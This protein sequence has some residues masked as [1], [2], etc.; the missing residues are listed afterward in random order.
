MQIPIP[1]NILIGP[2]PICINGVL[3]LCKVI[4]FW[5]RRFKN[6]RKCHPL[7]TCVKTSLCHRWLCTNKNTCVKS[8]VGCTRN[9][10]E[11]MENNR[12]SSL[13]GNK[14]GTSISILFILIMSTVSLLSRGRSDA[15]QQYLV[16][17]VSSSFPSWV[18]AKKPRSF[19]NCA[20]VPRFIQL[21]HSRLI[22]LFHV[23]RSSHVTRLHK[24][25]A[26]YNFCSF[27]LG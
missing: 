27:T 6:T 14:E 26:Q 10:S 24:S 11:G 17:I 22:Y 19:I 1:I 12:L 23:G 4:Q 25:Y 2:L 7:H 18:F 5:I 3:F 15:L 20:T 13:Y 21:F 8:A 16:S 9:S